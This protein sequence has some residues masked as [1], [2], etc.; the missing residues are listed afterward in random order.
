MAST[1]QTRQSLHAPKALTFVTS[2]PEHGLDGLGRWKKELKNKTLSTIPATLMLYYL[3]CRV[4]ALIHFVVRVQ[5]LGFY[6]CLLLRGSGF[7][8][9]RL[10]GLGVQGLGYSL[11]APTRGLGLAHPRPCTQRCGPPAA[12]RPWEAQGERTTA[13]DSGYFFCA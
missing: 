5:G 6:R 9:F 7:S 4:A 13:N 1:R 8:G 11:Q 10:S 12:E 2:K 3:G